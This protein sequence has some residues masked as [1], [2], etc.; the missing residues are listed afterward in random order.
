M[1]GG[2]VYASNHAVLFVCLNGFFTAV[3]EYKMSFLSGAAGIALVVFVLLFGLITVGLLGV[4]AFALTKLAQKLDVLTG[5]ISPVAVKI[6]DTVDTVQR[7]TMNVGERAD[8]ILSRS[9]AM[10]DTVASKVEQTARVVHDSVTG[11]LINVSSILTGVTTAFS[12]LGGRSGVRTK[13]SDHN[14]TNKEV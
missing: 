11:P 6:G 5:V 14:G 13:G 3:G 2:R 4:V 7:V 10:T 8:Q 1:L 12:S 9:E